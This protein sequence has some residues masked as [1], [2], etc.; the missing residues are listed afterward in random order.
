[1]L[2]GWNGLAIAAFAETARA[3]GAGGDPALRRAAARYLEAAVGAAEAVL[4]GLKGPDGRLR[5]SWKDGRATAGGVLEDYANLADGL[6]ALYEATFDERWYRDAVAL[7]DIVLERFADDAGGFFDTPD[8]GEPLVVRPKD[9]QDNA[10]PSGNA[11]MTTGSSAARGAHRRAAGTGWPPSG[12][13]PRSGRSSRGI[14]RASPSGCV[15]WSWRMRG[16]PRW[17]SSARPTRPRRRAWS[18][19]R[20]TATRR[21]GSWPPR[22]I[23]R[24]PPCRCSTTG[25]RSTGGDGVRVPRLRLPPARPRAGGARGPA[26]PRLT[27]AARRD[28]AMRTPPRLA[29]TVALLRDGPDG[30]EVLL[31]K[32]PAT[33]AFGPRLHVFPG[34]ALD[35]DDSD[36]RAAR[37][38]ARRRPGA[39]RRGLHGGPFVVAAIREAWEEAGVLLAS[40]PGTGRRA[41]AGGRGRR[42]VPGA[43]SSAHDLALRGDW[44]TPLSR[45]VTPPVVPRR[46]DARFFV[47]WLPDGAVPTFD[48]RE[49]AGHD[50]MTP[51]AAL[52]AMADGRIELW[53]PTSTTL[54][55]LAGVAT[56]GRPPGSDRGARSRRPCSRRSQGP[57]G[58]SPA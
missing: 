17:R 15:R 53:M 8:D 58:S 40:G 2:A 45:W 56:L 28:A 13:S 11:M 5:R 41:R 39:I 36:P 43:S 30:P 3:L 7:V 42:L 18:G 19:R 23:R 24:R 6:L 37:P 12:R 25:S 27:D 32:R 1:M 57:A 33:M 10:T 35:P 44:L 51:A 46:F 48:A 16:S 49:V 26:R 52:E 38:A 50:W 34:G 4:A 21:S 14:R 55:Q 20:A 22:P 54:Q 29:A 9:L 47:A 31:T